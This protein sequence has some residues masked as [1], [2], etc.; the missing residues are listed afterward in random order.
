VG[1][2]RVRCTATA[3]S[4]F[5][6]MTPHPTHR[7]RFGGASALFR[8]GLLLDFVGSGSRTW[9]GAYSSVED[10]PRFADVLNCLTTQ[11]LVAKG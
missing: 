6:M 10:L 11:I 4:V 3:T 9:V 5:D 8:R 7:N 1:R 2:S